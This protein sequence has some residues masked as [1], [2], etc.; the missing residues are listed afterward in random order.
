[1]R[2]KR[3]DLQQSD[4]GELFGAIGVDDFCRLNG[5][6]RSFFYKLARRGQGPQVMKIG[7]RLLV[8][9]GQRMIGGETV[10][11]ELPA[12]EGSV[13]DPRPSVLDT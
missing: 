13:P 8:A 3:K 9:P 7:A 1:M 4:D 6:S 5:I 11:A 12:R 10:I 2:R